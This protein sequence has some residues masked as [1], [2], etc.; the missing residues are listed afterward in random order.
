MRRDK[1]PDAE[2][3]R[4]REDDFGCVRK[5]GL[6]KTSG[7]AAILLAPTPGI[8]AKWVELRFSP[9]TDSSVG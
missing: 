8:R 1:V 9:Q 6:E 3:I 4:V 7:A 2:E 5:A